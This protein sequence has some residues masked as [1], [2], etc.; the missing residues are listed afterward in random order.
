MYER[1]ND[2]SYFEAVKMELT[3]EQSVEEAFKD[4]TYVIH[5]ASPYPF[6]NPK[7]EDD[8]LQPA[9]EGTK[10]ILDKCKNHQVKKVVVTSSIHSIIDYNREGERN[11]FFEG[12]EP[13]EITRNTS[14]YA[15]SK[16]QA[17]E[18]VKSF[19]SE[20]PDQEKFDVVILNPGYMFG[21]L[22]YNHHCTSED[23]FVKILLGRFP[24]LPDIYLPTVDVRDVAEAHYKAI[25][26]DLKYEQ[27]IIAKGKL[28]SF[29]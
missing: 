27:Y 7:N 10:S 6:K 24:G 23:I 14:T 16:L 29:V 1:F 28:K 13:P 26:E 12:N 11:K 19:I 21:P 5:T 4:C 9:V 15:K 8:V 17:E 3:D 22:F 20:L 2:K 18:A 25:V